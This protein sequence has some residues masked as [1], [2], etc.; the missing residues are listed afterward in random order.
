MS[1]SQ[2]SM[3]PFLKSTAVLDIKI[4]AAF[5][6]QLQNTLVYLMDGHAEDIAALEAKGGQGDLTYWET[7]VVTITT[8]L[9]EIMRV[10]QE[11][12]EIDYKD[13]TEIAEQLTTE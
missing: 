3:I 4:G 9:Q 1:D 8:I 6:Q 10:A 2:E 13:S 5:V 12:G 7:S 11:T